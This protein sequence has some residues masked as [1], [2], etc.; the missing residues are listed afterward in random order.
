MHA[1]LPFVFFFEPATEVD[2]AAA[3][4]LEDAAV[5]VDFFLV[6]FGVTK[7]TTNV[8]PPTKFSVL[9]LFL[10]GLDPLLHFA[11]YSPTKSDTSTF[12]ERILIA[13]LALCYH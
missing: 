9:T 3:A 13:N 12:A 4:L 5:E 1:A 6:F 7:P 10:F 8:S 2:G 11:L